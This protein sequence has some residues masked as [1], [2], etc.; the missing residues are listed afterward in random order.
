MPRGLSPSL[1]RLLVI[2]GICRSGPP[3]YVLW[4]IIDWLRTDWRYAVGFAALT[5]N[6]VI[7]FLLTWTAPS[8]MNGP[9]R[10]RPW[11]TFLL[12]INMLVLPIMFY[13]AHGHLPW[14]FF[15]ATTYCVACLYVG[16]AIYLHLHQK[17]PMNS[18]FVP[19]SQSKPSAPATREQPT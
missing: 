14:I 6:Y 16:T 10:V 9:W 8:L 19:Q 5:L 4:S 13:R 12:A 2:K 3:V 18:V 17:L 15:L 1:T 11:Q 7:V